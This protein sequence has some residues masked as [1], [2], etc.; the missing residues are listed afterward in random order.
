[1]RSRFGSRVPLRVDLDELSIPAWFE[2]AVDLGDDFL[3]L[4][5]GEGE[6]EKTLV[7][8][9]ELGGPIGREGGRRSY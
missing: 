7:D 6:D 1:M 8:E 5:C 2:Y 9:A 3:P 4:G